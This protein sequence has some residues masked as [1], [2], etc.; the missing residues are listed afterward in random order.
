MGVDHRRPD[1]GMTEECLDRADVVVRLQK[2]GGKGMAKR[3][4]RYPLGKLSFFHN[5]PADN[6]IYS[7]M[8]QGIVLAGW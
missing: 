1:V 5:N 3:V 6:K 8:F 2:V 7:P 4:S